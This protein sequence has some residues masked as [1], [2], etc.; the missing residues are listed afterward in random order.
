MLTNRRNRTIVNRIKE[1]LPKGTITT[2]S[3]ARRRIDQKFNKNYLPKDIS[4]AVKDAV[5]HGSKGLDYGTLRTS[6]GKERFLIERTDTVSIPD[7]VDVR[8]W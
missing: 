3:G 2:P 6:K 4:E 8:V 5:N 1:V 7:T